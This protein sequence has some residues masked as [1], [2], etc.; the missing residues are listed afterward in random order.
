MKLPAVLAD[1]AGSGRAHEVSGA[2][3]ATALSDLFRQEPGLR[4][5]VIDERGALRPHVSVFVDGR[6]ARLDTEIGEQAEIWI[7]QA[8]S[9]GG[10]LPA[11]VPET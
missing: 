9:G 6:Q 11:P 3:V 2:D 1:V 5:H 7:L 10:L 4:T 8:V